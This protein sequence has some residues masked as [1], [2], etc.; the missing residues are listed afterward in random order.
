MIENHLYRARI[1]VY[2]PNKVH[3]TKCKS[4]VGPG[5]ETGNYLNQNNNTTKKILLVNLPIFYHYY[6]VINIVYGQIVKNHPNFQ[7]T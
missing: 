1:G 5:I 2:N 4:K 3:R 6:I 7:L